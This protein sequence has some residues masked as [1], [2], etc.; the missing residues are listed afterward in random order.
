MVIR[1][2]WHLSK[3][4]DASG[5]AQMPK[6]QMNQMV[7]ILQPLLAALILKA[8]RCV[9]PALAFAWSMSKNQSS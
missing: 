5:S 6:Q 7:L 8:K 4:T 3:L 1:K 9:K 2:G